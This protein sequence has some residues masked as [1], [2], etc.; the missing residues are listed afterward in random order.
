MGFFCNYFTINERRTALCTHLQCALARWEQP[1]TGLKISVIALNPLDTIS[2]VYTRRL[3]PCSTQLSASHPSLP[4][5]GKTPLPAQSGRPGALRGDLPTRARRCQRCPSAFP[6][7]ATPLL[8]RRGR[9]EPAGPGPAP[10]PPPAASP[11]PPERPRRGRR[12]SHGVEGVGRQGAL[13]AQLRVQ[14]QVVLAVVPP[15]PRRRGVALPRGVGLR[16][17]HAVPRPR[18][19]PAQRLPRGA[20][21]AA[22]RRSGR[23]RLSPGSA[24][25]PLAPRPGSEGLPAAGA[26]AR[27]AA[28][29]AQLGAGAAKFAA[30]QPARL[31]PAGGKGR[32]VGGRRAPLASPGASVPPARRRPQRPEPA[33]LR[34]AAPAWRRCPGQG[35]CPTD[36]LA[37]TVPAASPGARPAVVSNERRRTL[38]WGFG[39]T[40]GA[41]G[42]E[43]S[44]CLGL[45][46]GLV[47]RPALHL[48]PRVSGR[49]R[50][51]VK[52]NVNPVHPENLQL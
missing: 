2:S 26:A 18:C 5:R 30:R 33:E 47:W 43:Q 25:A 7:T 16:L 48:C 28:G 21:A 51:S 4:C 27:R 40:G 41:A 6:S 52:M 15:G 13:L 34:P 14:Q 24:A 39:R 29:E 9:G 23:A 37:G 22:R 42:G 46:F 44:S 3:F 38:L 20:P 12:D 1:I 17:A 50:A 8:P 32:E 36:R 31:S 45:L 49:G 19:G 10:W 35:P 11:R